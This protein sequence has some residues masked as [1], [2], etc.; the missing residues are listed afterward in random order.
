M[1]PS[2][3]GISYTL[4]VTAIEVISKKVLMGRPGTRFK[5][6]IC[7]SI[8]RSDPAFKSQVGRFYNQRSKVLH[9]VGVGM[10]NIPMHGIISFDVIGGQDLWRL[11]IYSN[12]AL[13]GF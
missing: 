13:L 9:N 10:R 1:N 5:E 4:F 12:A 7:T 8:E 11:E 3:N 6:F 2:N